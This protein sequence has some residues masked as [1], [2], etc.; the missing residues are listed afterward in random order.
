MKRCCIALIGLV[1]ACAIPNW[2]LAQRSNLYHWTPGQLINY[3]IHDDFI[4]TMPGARAA[5]VNA[6][7][8]WYNDSAT[9]IRLNFAGTTG[10]GSWVIDSRQCPTG[11]EN[12]VVMSYSCHPL[13][14]EV[15]GLTEEACCDSSRVNCTRF[16]ITTYFN[17]DHYWATHMPAAYQV[18]LMGNMVHEFGHALDLGH[19]T[20]PCAYPSVMCQGDME[21]GDT[22][23]RHLFPIDRLNIEAAYG[24]RE[25]VVRHGYSYDDVTWSGSSAV[26]S[27]KYTTTGPAAAFGWV[28]VFYPYY[29][30][31]WVD[32]Q[33]NATPFSYPVNSINR[34]DLSRHHVF[35]QGSFVAPAMVFDPNSTTP[36]HFVAWPV[37]EQSGHYLYYASSTNGFSTL[38]CGQAIGPLVFSDG[39]NNFLLQTRDTPAMAYDPYS[40]RIFVAWVHYDPDCSQADAAAGSTLCQAFVDSSNVTHRLYDRQILLASFASGSSCFNT[41]TKLVDYQFDDT[42]VAGLAMACNESTTYRNCLLAVPGTDSNNSIFFIPFGFHSDGTLWSK[43]ASAKTPDSDSSQTNLGITFDDGTF[44]AAWRGDEAAAT[45]ISRPLNVYSVTLNYGNPQFV[46]KAVLSTR[47]THGPALTADSNGTKFMVWTY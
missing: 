19:P 22:K 35:D 7:Y 32:S 4:S 43:G 25:E 45:G 46:Q 38:D 12:K 10:D 3:K 47:S 6:S 20:P 41:V 1:F 17:S 5:I 26:D 29:G 42:A 30:I 24:D 23:W 36:R 14:C 2:S 21:E 34:F 18:D 33:E 31:A 8:A 44:A 9:A 16:R 37:R 28:P 40:Q 11:L 15:L 13:G 27:T 39:T